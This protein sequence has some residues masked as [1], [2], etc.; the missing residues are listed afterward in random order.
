[1]GGKGSKR[2]SLPICYCDV[3]DYKTSNIGRVIVW[4]T[5]RR[6]IKAFPPL[7]KIKC[8]KKEK[9]PRPMAV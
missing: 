2:K 5:G 1:M 4:Y 6:I 7:K 9:N 8:G 3:A